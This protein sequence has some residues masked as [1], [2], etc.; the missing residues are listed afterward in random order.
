MKSAVPFH[1]LILGR[2]K[3][4]G[5]NQNHRNQGTI[6][7]M[8]DSDPSSCLQQGYLW[9]EYRLL[10]A[11]SCCI[12]K[13]FKVGDFPPWWIWP[14]HN[15]FGSFFLFFALSSPPSILNI[16]CFYSWSPIM[17]CSEELPPSSW[18]SL[19]DLLLYLLSSRV[20]EGCCW[21]P[22]TDP[23]CRRLS[24]IRKPETRCRVLDV[25]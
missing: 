18:L 5:W 24:C 20:V 10:R 4:W 21:L 19:T 6:R 11:L 22:W 2:K 16:C 1:D 3:S 15:W 7:V 25:A 9:G 8:K 23:V 13:N 12:L 17:H 14:L